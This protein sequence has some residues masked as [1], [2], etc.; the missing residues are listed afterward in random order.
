MKMRHLHVQREFGSEGSQEPLL[1][2]EDEAPHHEIMG[3]DAEV[4]EIEATSSSLDSRT[5]SGQNDQNG[6]KRGISWSRDT[7]FGALSF[8]LA[9]F[10]LPALY[11]TLAKLWVA[12]IDSSMVV[13]TE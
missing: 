10:I 11:S 4:S 2:A 12:K 8:N 3:Y 1:P 6:G 5:R 13:T 9:A 7:Y